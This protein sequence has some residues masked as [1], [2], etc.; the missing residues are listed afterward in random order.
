MISSPQVNSRELSGSGRQELVW[1]F[2]LV[3]N[4]AEVTEDPQRP[5]RWDRFSKMLFW[6]FYKD[7]SVYLR[8][9]GSL[10]FSRVCVQIRSGCSGR[11]WR[12]LRFCCP[13]VKRALA[14]CYW[15][16]TVCSPS[17]Q[18]CSDRAALTR[19]DSKP[20]ISN[21]I[22]FYFEIKKIM[23]PAGDARGRERAGPLES[24]GP[25]AVEN[26][27][28]CIS[29]TQNG[30]FPSDQSPRGLLWYIPLSSHAG[31]SLHLTLVWSCV[32]HWKSG[33]FCA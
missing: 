19:S 31:V 25:S 7:G 21:I 33:R 23:W 5:P 8:V 13:A 29:E 3:W 24:C 1:K 4:V 14:A 20:L 18:S 11:V 12:E 15:R 30:S 10:I 6:T 26:G 22:T 2:P 17:L 28:E 27:S 16:V 9:F 32:M